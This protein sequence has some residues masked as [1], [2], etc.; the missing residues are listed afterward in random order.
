MEREMI[1][2]YTSDLHGNKEHYQ[3]LFELAEQKE[4]Q[5]I[6]IGGDILPIGRQV[7]GSNLIRP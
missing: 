3:E 5:T 7:Q 2:V 1:I 6:I 4:A